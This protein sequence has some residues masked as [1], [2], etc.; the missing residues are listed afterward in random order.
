MPNWRLTL[1]HT[2]ARGDEPQTQSIVLTEGERCTFGRGKDATVR[3]DTAACSR[4]HCFITLVNDE[5]FLEDAGSSNGTWLNGQRVKRDKI[6]VGD[7]VAAGH[8]VIR[9]AGLEPID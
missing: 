6:K 7:V 5:L 4:I 9:I 8:P 2:T 3:F 1:V